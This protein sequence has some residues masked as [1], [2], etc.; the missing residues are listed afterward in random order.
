MSE[1]VRIKGTI[2]QV[3]SIINNTTLEEL[4]KYEL[5]KLNNYDEFELPVWCNSYEEYLLDKYYNKYIVRNGKLYEID[6]KNC[7]LIDE[8]FESKFINSC[9]A[10]EFHASYHNGGCS[11][12]EAINECMDNVK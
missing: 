5:F 6:V 11:L 12:H 7:D 1:Q 3:T 2:H 4:C 9:G 10:I 8:F